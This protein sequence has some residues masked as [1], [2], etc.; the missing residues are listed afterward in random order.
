MIGI[1]AGFDVDDAVCRANFVLKP[2]RQLHTARMEG[3]PVPAVSIEVF[4]IKRCAIK[5]DGPIRK[6]L[7]QPL[8]HRKGLVPGSAIAEKPTNAG[9][10]GSIGQ[11]QEGRVSIVHH[12]SED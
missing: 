12:Y 4:R 8:R 1:F 3:N 11:P 9:F 10:F 2:P 5:L 6:L 7:P